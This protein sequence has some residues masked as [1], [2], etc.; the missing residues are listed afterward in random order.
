MPVPV[1]FQAVV[2]AAGK[3]SRMLEITSG[4]PK[5][6]L[7]VGPKPLIWYTLRKLQITGF[8]EAILIVLETQKAEIQSAIERELEGNSLDIKVDYVSIAEDQED[9]GTADSLRLVQERLKSDVLVVSCDLVSDVNLG[10][11]LNL[12]R[13]HNA[14][15]ASLMFYHQASE[16]IVVPGPKSK[17]KP[18]KDLIGI[19]EQTQRLVFM[20]SVSD[21]ESQVTLPLSLLKKHTLVKMYSTLIDSHVYVLKNW[22]I[23]YL[24]S[25]RSITSLKGELIPYIVKKQLSKPQKIDEVNQSIIN[26]KDSNDIFS[27]AEEDELE[28]AI[29]EISSFNDHNGD[30]KSSYNNDPIRCYAYIAPKGSIGLRVNTLPA[31]WSINGK[32]QEVWNKVSINMSLIQKSPQANIQSNQVDDKCIISDG[33]KLN[34]KTSF[35]NANIG[36]NTTVNSFSRVFNSIV[37][38][39]VMIHE[40]V[41]LENCIVCD[42]A[43]IEKGSSLKNCIV[44]NNHLVQAESECTNELLT[45]DLMHF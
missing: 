29:R 6:L 3:G 23:Q 40:K 9:L 24:K 2:L 42:N 35:K 33:A 37:M 13:K 19:D 30:L 25:E 45:E 22:V 38:N 14:S 18:E 8:N 26:T 4:H 7:P 44:G 16:P 27:F 10:G 41:A 5:C 15:I 32:I 20:A 31:Y 34:E 36:T 43:V 1:E 11:V 39:N 17:H 28:L 21:F 12:F